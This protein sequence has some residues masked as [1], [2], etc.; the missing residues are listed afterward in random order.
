VLAGKDWPV[1]QHLGQ[2]AAHRPDVDRLGVALKKGHLVSA[3]HGYAQYWG[4]CY[5]HN[6][7]QFLAKKWRFS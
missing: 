5:D 2:D 4:Q 6:I 7:L 1:G 3:L